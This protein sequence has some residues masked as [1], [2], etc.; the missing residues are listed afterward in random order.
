MSIIYVDPYRFAAVPWTP[1]EITTELWLDAADASTITESGG[2]VSQWDDKSGNGRDVSQATAAARPQYALAGLNGRNVVT[3][4]GSNSIE[5]AS[6]F[7]MADLV[8]TVAKRSKTDEPVAETDLL[9][10]SFDR[11]LW[12]DF[13][14]FTTHSSYSTNGGSLASFASDQLNSFNIVAGVTRT[15]P[16]SRRLLVGYGTPG[17]EYLIGGIAEIVATNDVGSK[18]IIEGYLA[19]KWGLT[20]DLPAGHPYKTTAP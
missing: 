16:D 20:A 9:V 11:G 13:S 7:V 14:G 19:H 6:G 4:N 5:T 2:A 12:G 17:F 1:A 8:V 18:Q 10:S 3:F 15:S